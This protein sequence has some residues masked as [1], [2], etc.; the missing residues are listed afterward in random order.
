MLLH[1][2][3]GHR[4]HV[5]GSVHYSD[6]SWSG[7]EIDDGIYCTNEFGIPSG[8][9]CLIELRCEVASRD[10]I[11]GCKI[12][13]LH[14]FPNRFLRGSEVV[15][16]TIQWGDQENRKA[17]MSGNLRPIVLKFTRR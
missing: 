7:R 16:S 17:D 3:H 13:A 2:R 15:I 5:P 8:H 9:Y 6:G 14:F 12:L 1:E 4:F 11:S 10:F